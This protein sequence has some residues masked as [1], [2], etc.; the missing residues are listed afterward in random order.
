MKQT[1]THFPNDSY[2]HTYVYSRLQ[3]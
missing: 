1:Y 3:I 2:E